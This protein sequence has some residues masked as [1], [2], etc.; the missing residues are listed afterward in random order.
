MAISIRRYVDITSGV[1]AAAQ[2]P[3]RELIGR[4]VTQNTKVLPGTLV[5][6]TNPDDIATF[7]G[8]DSDENRIGIK[9][10]AFINKMNNRAKKIGFVNWSATGSAPVLTGDNTVKNVSDFQA[11]TTASP[12]TLTL[13]VTVS[14]VTTPATVSGI[15]WSGLPATNWQAQAASILQ[16]RIRA[17]TGVPQL[18][19]ANVTATVSGNNTQFSIAGSVA[20]AATIIAVATGARDTSVVLG[21]STPGAVPSPGVA[22]QA[23]VDAI[24]QSAAASD[25][26]GSFA[27]INALQPSDQDAVASWNDSQNN[28]FMFCTPGTI[29]TANALFTALQGFSG[30]GVSLTNSTN[31]ADKTRDWAEICPMEILA[32]TDYTRA[33]S[34][35]NYM[36]YQ[37]TDRAAM[38]SDDMTADQ[39][40]PLRMN[41]VGQSQINGKSLTFYQRGVLMGGSTAAVDMNTYANEMWLKSRLVADIMNAFLGLPSIPANEIGRAILMGV[42]QSSIDA[43]LFNGVISVGKPITTV[44]KAFIT[45]VTDDPNAW[46]QVQTRGYWLNC[47]I[48]SY[49]APSG[50]TE[51]KAVYLLVYSKDDQIRKV[52]GTNTLI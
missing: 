34:S 6:M 15:D 16:T 29:G 18:A 23:A 4:I 25:N 41:Y 20:Q 14:G 8:V 43:A 1:G 39:M 48:Q 52:E 28:K 46:Y 30:T 24:S 44:Q 31:T 38:V 45:Q 37:F 12:G 10:F 11:F 7:F 49:V 22:A 2:V 9:Y 27:F 26:F 51:W 35:Q 36:Y 32:A 42:I 17:V 19:N 50:V 21:V 40:D 3:Y 13:N 5:E 47:T 33:N